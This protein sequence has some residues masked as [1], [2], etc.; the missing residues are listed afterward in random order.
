MYSNVGGPGN[1]EQV[2]LVRRSPHTSQ[3]ASQPG[4]WE[5]TTTFNQNCTPSVINNS[6]HMPLGNGGKWEMRWQFLLENLSLACVLFFYLSDICVCVFS[7]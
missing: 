7:D 1:P 4:G 2:S 5:E 3:P 6:L